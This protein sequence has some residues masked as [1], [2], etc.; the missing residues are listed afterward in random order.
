[1]KTTTFHGN[2]FIAAFSTGTVLTLT[3]SRRTLLA[4]AVLM[5]ALPTLTACGTDE[6][7][8]AADTGGE[9]TQAP[10]AALTPDETRELAG[11][12][13]G[14]VSV[15]YRI[16]GQPVVGQPVA[17]DLEV[18]SE[19]GAKPV[20]LSYRI[21]DDS[22]MRLAPSQPNRAALLFNDQRESGTQQV[23]VVPQREGRLFLNVAA[24]VKTDGGTIST[25][26]AVPI[27]VGA[28]PDGA[29]ENG[30]VTTDENGERIRVLPAEES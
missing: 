14:P 3:S 30:T 16:I 15:A 4:I 13:T 9:E 23:M 29:E 28:A 18:R 26:T 10:A 17:I 24:E 5:L 22:A 27:R 1:M 19:I 7:E 12:P 20:T 6:A 11:K 2:P 25:V 8:Q 21:N